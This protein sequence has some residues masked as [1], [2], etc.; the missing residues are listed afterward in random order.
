M[1]ESISEQLAAAIEKA[2]KPPR[3]IVRGLPKP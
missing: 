2:G 3:E 1:N